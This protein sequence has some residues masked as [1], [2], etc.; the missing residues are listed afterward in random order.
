MRG[1][2]GPKGPERPLIAVDSP[3]DDEE[4]VIHDC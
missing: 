2:P 4:L 3:P 1:V